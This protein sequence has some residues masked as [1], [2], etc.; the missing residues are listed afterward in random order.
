MT[1]ARE[2]QVEA[3]MNNRNGAPCLRKRVQEKELPRQ[4]SCHVSKHFDDKGSWTC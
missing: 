2:V 4:T 1:G 3:G